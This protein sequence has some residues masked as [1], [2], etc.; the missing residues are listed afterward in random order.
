MN[1]RYGQLSDFRLVLRT[2]LQSCWTDTGSTPVC[3][4]LIYRTV[5]I[6]AGR[7]EVVFLPASLMNS[8]EQ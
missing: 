2:L 1:L 3:L 8:L 6:L 5:L 4:P 7:E